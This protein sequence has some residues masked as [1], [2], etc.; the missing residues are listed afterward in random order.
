MPTDSEK[1]QTKK[2]LKFR[3][4]KV[5]KVKSGE[6]TASLRLFDDKNLT[7]GDELDMVDSDTGETF[8]HATITEVIAKPLKDI[9]EADLQGHERYE[10]LAAMLENFHGFYGDRVTLETRAKIIRFTVHD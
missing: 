5:E 8:A 1:S 6:K 7:V 4:F 9:E 2:S 10:S 3:G